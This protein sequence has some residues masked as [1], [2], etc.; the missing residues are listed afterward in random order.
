MRLIPLKAVKETI[1][2][3]KHGIVTYECD[4]VVKEP[5][6]ILLD[7][8]DGEYGMVIISQIH[9]GSNEPVRVVMRPVHTPVKKYSIN[10]VVAYLAVF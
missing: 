4:Q 3:K 7:N 5:G 2:V 10:D 6:V 9:N 8:K 1:D